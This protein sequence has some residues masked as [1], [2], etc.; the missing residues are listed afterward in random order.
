M[1]TGRGLGRPE[2]TRPDADL[3]QVKEGGEGRRQAERQH[4]QLWSS[5]EN[6]GKADGGSSGQV[7][8]RRV[9]PSWEWVYFMLLLLAVTGGRGLWEAWPLRTQG[10][11]VCLM[12]EGQAP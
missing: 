1:E 7:P 3:K 9:P 2:S 12:V 10:L 6:F 5:S 8:V 4:L 11:V